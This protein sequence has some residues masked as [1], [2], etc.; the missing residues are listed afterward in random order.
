MKIPAATY[1]LQFHAGWTL[2]QVTDL[3]PY[4]HELG[5][6]HVYAS[7]L[8]QARR[9]STHGYDVCDPGKINA[10]IGD[11]A[12]LQAFVD[13]LHKNGMGLVLDIVPN[14]LAAVPENPRWRDVLKF[15]RHSRFA[16][17]FDIDWESPDP[18]LRDKVLLPMLGTDL[19]TAVKRGE[20]CATYIEG[21]LVIGYFEH[22][23]PVCPESHPPL[24]PS[25]EDKV[26]ELNSNPQ[27]LLGLLGEQHYCLTNWREADS[28]INYR[29]FFTVNELAGVR[30]E[31]PHVFDD[32]HAHVLDWHRRGFID[33]LRIDHPDGMADPVG[34][35]ERLK[36]AAPEAWVVVEKVLEPGEALP[37]NW[38]VAGTTGYEFAERVSG[39]SIDPDGEKALTD[40]YA[41]FT[42]ESVDYAALAREKKRWTLRHSLAAG[43]N[44]LTRLL[45]S[46]QRARNPEAPADFV[47]LKA[48]LVEVMAC[49]PVYRSYF[50][51]EI[52]HCLAD[53][54]WLGQALADARKALA[55]VSPRVFDLIADVFLG[56][57]K[58]ERETDLVLEFTGRFQQLT[59][60]AM[61]KGVE[62]TAFY[63]F[64][65]FIARNEV[66]AS[67]DQF[68]VTVEEFHRACDESLAQWPHA[69]LTTSTHDTKRSEDVRARLA[70]LSEIPDEWASAVRR[71]SRLAERHRQGAWPDRNAEYLYYQTLVGAWPLDAERAVAFMVKAAREAKVHTT[72]TESSEGYESAVIRFVR[73]TLADREFSDDIH[74]FV[75]SIQNAGCLNSL[76]QTL[77][78]LTAP[79][80]PD[81]YQGTE[82]WDRSLVDPDNR[83]PVDFARRRLALDGIKKRVSSGVL[84][85]VAQELLASSD[86]GE[87]KLYL[88]YQ[89]LSLRLRHSS[90]FSRGAYK[91]LAAEGALAKH[92]CAF[93]RTF[94]DD[95]VA[96]IVPRLSHSLVTAA[97]GCPPLGMKLWRDTR[98]LLPEE[99]SGRTFRNVFT[100]EV[101]PGEEAKAPR[102]WFAGDVFKMFPM[103]L[104]G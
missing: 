103:A 53:R 94:G 86:E 24:G 5:I 56:A 45:D 76:A 34:Y 20:I 71:W 99:L 79:G 73:G 36:D 49:F 95:T 38:P 21:E 96:V 61:A 88:I 59:A 32:L 6:S 23:F 66:G 2:R 100:G 69:M 93:A 47:L 64:N 54:K 90:L 80:V 39:L 75:E 58:G 92:V 104:L 72:W 33:G 81:I 82:L 43:V 74:R 85:S 19:P 70:V 11:E 42:R 57:P 3:V 28:C 29:R 83:R 51:H 31:L 10:E 17:W 44:R 25:T 7:P 68:A 67:P 9:H 55:T 102:Q 1:R 87:I 50:R 91:P 101:H 65:R 30:V 18:R 97:G 8:L 13:A 62:D 14:H 12:D 60:A 52:N 63:C 35:L 4:L 22:H 26:R 37:P 15:G 89:T 98:I 77:L 78:K 46:I 41:A 40:L 16:D 84:S 27:R 48:A